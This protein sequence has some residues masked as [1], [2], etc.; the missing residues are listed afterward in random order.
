[1]KDTF[2]N[3]VK[4]WIHCKGYGHTTINH[5]LKQSG[6]Q[7]EPG[8]NYCAGCLYGRGIKIRGIK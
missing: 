2:L 1:M 4:L 5:I 6:S 3:R 7:R 8:I